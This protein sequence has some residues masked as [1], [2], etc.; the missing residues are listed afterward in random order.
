MGP[1]ISAEIQ[2]DPALRILVERADAEVRQALR[3]PAE[4]RTWFWSPSPGPGSGATLTLTYEGNVGSRSFSTA[5]LADPKAVGWESHELWQNVL[6][7]NIGR[8][9]ERIVS[10]LREIDVP[11]PLQVV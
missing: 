10:L 8:T 11:Q 6:L 1:T 2:A 4:G 5:E 9:S 3:A 7:A